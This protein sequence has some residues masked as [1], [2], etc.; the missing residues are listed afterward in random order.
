MDIG[1]AIKELRKKKGLG[2][3]DLAAMCNLSVNAISQIETNTT[4]PHREN[5][6][7]ICDALETDMTNILL[8][9]ITDMNVDEKHKTIFNSLLDSIKSIT[10]L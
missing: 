7:K 4:F 8:Y 9:A 3:R 1:T 2:Q 10:R 6:I 5:I